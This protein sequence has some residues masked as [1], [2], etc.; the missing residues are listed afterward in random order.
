MS[1]RPRNVQLSAMWI[2]DKHVLKKTKIVEFFSNIF[3]TTRNSKISNQHFSQYSV[4]KFRILNDFRSSGFCRKIFHSK[5]EQNLKTCKKFP[6]RL[7]KFITT[8]F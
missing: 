8:V 2:Q 3:K 6:F 1:H 4:L 5:F 7:M